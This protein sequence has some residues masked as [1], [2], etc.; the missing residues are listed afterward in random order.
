MIFL[1]QY[2]FPEIL[3]MFIKVI[4]KVRGLESSMHTSTINVYSTIPITTY[5]CKGKNRFLIFYDFN[6]WFYIESMTVY[7]Y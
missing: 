3:Q 6:Y 1:N 7:I 2:N 4:A 5:T